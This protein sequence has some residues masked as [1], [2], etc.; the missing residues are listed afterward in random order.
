MATVTRK[1][2]ATWPVGEPFELWP[3]M[4]EITLE[5]VMR[6]VFGP[7]GRGPPRAP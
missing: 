5:A 3:R 4:Q 1:E 7:A 2:V 6:V